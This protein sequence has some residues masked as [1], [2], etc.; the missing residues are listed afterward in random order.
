MTDG[1]ADILI[2]DDLPEN[3][4]ALEA[5]LAELG[6][7]IVRATSGQEALRILLDREFAV[8]LLDVRMPKMDGFETAA[9]IRMRA[10]SRLT[11]IIFMTAGDTNVEAVAR[12]YSAGAVDFITK[13][14][15]DE[16]LR[17]KV[18]VFVDLFLK[19]KELAQKADELIRTNQE[20]RAANQQLETFS[21]T[22]AHNLRAPLRAMAGFCQILREEYSGKPFDQLGQDYASRVE[23]GAQQMDSLIQELLS[24]CRIAQRAVH[25]EKVDPGSI[26][27]DV[28]DRKAP[29]LHGKCDVDVSATIPP[30]RGDRE[31]LHHAISHLVSNAATFSK[32]R[33][34][35]QIRIKY[36]PRPG[37]VRLWVEDNGIG[38][39][40]EYHD[41]I[42][43][44]FER[45][46][47]GVGFP[48]AGMGLAIVKTAMERMGGRVGVESEPGVGSRFWI[49]LPRCREA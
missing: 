33:V 20:L 18:K 45:L 5:I 31:L 35:S 14:I 49:E 21:Y 23:Q 34:R 13:P 44:A 42:F 12:G 7:H 17:S 47:D 9:F 25:L 36:E 26:I 46:H 38:I 19:G 6:Q 27:K 41:R 29:L 8:I 28:L 39:P 22:V 37:K 40:R 11:P 32:P 3:L 10:Q 30:I 43:G 16:M 48:G 1:R 15:Q 4:L 2:V 24:L